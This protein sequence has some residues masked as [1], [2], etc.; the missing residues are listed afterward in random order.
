MNSQGRDMRKLIVLRK[1]VFAGSF[2]PYWIIAGFGKDIFMK[3]Y[4]FDGDLCEMNAEGRPVP[5]ITMEELDNI[6]IRI[7]N[8]QIKEISV[9]DDSNSLFVSTIDGCLSN[10]INVD[11]C[12]KT[13]EGQITINTRGGFKNLSYPV[14]EC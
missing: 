9:A 2:L 6:G 7:N 3:K 14:V 8:G 5:R 10:E 12:L 13:R 1:K 11:D 4:N